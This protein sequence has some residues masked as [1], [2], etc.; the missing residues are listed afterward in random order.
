ML[1]DLHV[2]EAEGMVLDLRVLEAGRKTC[3]PHVLEVG[4]R[5]L[6]LH[7]LEA[8][9]DAS[10]PPRSSYEAGEIRQTLIALNNCY[11]L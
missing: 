3:R 6:D 1:L 7:V 2:L 8:G 11:K 4:R 9:R 10:I 5:L